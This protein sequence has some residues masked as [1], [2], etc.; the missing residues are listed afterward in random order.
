MCMSR[1]PI[2]DCSDLLMGLGDIIMEIK[3]FFYL[4]NNFEELYVISWVM[5]QGRRNEESQRFDSSGSRTR[6]CSRYVRKCC[7]GLVVSN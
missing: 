4:S 2:T 7:L 3:Y 5:W 6:N 1:V